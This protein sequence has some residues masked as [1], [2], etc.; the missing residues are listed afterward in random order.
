[1]AELDRCYKLT[2]IRAPDVFDADANGL[3][4]DFFEELETITEFTSADGTGHQIEFEVK[5]NLLAHPNTCDIV[6][7]N[8][9]EASRRS[10]IDFPAKIKLEAGYDNT[11]RLLFLGDLRYASNEKEGTEWQTKLQVADGA[12]AYAHARIN[13]SYSKGTPISSI[14]AD[15]ARAFGV[16]VPFQA[17]AS[18]ILSTRIAAGEVLTG[19][20]ADEL[21]RILAPMGFGYSFQDGK[22]QLLRVDD[23]VPGTARIIS[24][25]D[26]MIG[27]PEM[28][29]PKI[30]APP[31]RA[32]RH[33]AGTA[34]RPRVPKLKVKHTLY[35]EITPG[36]K[37]SVI[38][39]SLNGL[40]R[41]DA[42]HHKGE[43]YGNEWTST[44]EGTTTSDTVK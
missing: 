36:E 31:K 14:V 25:E 37:V 10:F 34:K 39:R 9:N 27:A 7:Y 40:F 8:L 6:I 43:F 15:L 13:K 17:R 21:T 18:N 2:V 29:P 44:I 42:I 30:I 1:M 3:G 20:V 16:P 4:H 19:D 35:P 26:G 33:R 11:P 38:S 23:V 32:V 22:L 12:R 5:K 24:E 28:V 41:V